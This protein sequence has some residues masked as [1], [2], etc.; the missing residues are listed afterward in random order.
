MPNRKLALVTGASSGIGRQYAIFLAK[1]GYDVVVVARR[2]E[3]LEALAIELKAFGAETKVVVADLST[4]DGIQAMLKEAQDVEFLVL[5]AGITRAAR[6]GQTDIQEMNRLNRLLATGVVEICEAVI[7][8]MIQRRSGDVVVVSSIAAFVEMPKSALYAAAK[9]YVMSYGRSVN[10]E[11]RG[12]GVR[13]CVVCPGYV[14]TQLHQNAG[15]EHLTSRV[16]RWLWVTADE[17]VR[18]AQKGLSQNK[19]VVIPG[20]VYRLARPFLNLSFA[21]R[22]WRSKTRRN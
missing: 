15:L 16:P 9:T 5:N 3:L 11:L 7:P 18:S 17:V 10:A 22:F 8:K 19:S 6:V 14:R 2:V 4:D 21:Q 13:L 1:S 20:F 12:S